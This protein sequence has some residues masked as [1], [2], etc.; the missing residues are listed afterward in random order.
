MYRVFR[1]HYNDRNGV[2]QDA[3]RW[4]VEFRDRSG[5]PHRIAAFEGQEASDEFGRNL[6]RLIEYQQASGGNVEP[7]MLAWIN[8]LSDEH[9][10]KLAAFGVIS[11]TVAGA[12]RQLDEHLADWRD[13]L[14]AEGNTSF[15]CDTYFKRAS[16]I[17]VGCK[18]R[19]P[20]DIVPYP[21]QS[22]LRDLRTQEARSVQT[23][24]HYLTAFKCFLRWMVRNRRMNDNPIEH[25]SGGNV[26][27]DPKHK[28]RN[29]PAEQF[30]LLIQAASVS[31]RTYRGLSGCDRLMI[32]L[33]AAYTGLREGEIASLKPDSF[34]F[35]S[36][37]SFVRVKPAH[38]KNREPVKLL[39]RP[40]LA[41]LLRDYI[42]ERSPHEPVWG[43]TWS[44][45]GAEMLRI[46][47]KPAGI[48]YELDGLFFDFHALRHQFISSLASAG[49]TPKM[50]QELARHSTITLT[51]DTYS[52]TS[53]NEQADALNRLPPLP[54]T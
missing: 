23:T 52:H 27:L 41:A 39:L 5:T 54:P 14:A 26:K 1:Q 36:P 18:F 50:A 7:A 45:D 48:P 49:V 37:S 16:R 44:Q 21:V 32:Y 15:H 31:T 11:A 40:D 3:P 22:F 20:S 4:T 51:L 29:V 24:N 35:G 10:D 38:V 9:R 2:R 19:M 53:V 28:R 17:V 47:L 12:S 30:A 43:G 33:L 34:S 25:L 6:T 13:S 46:D 8:G 42:A